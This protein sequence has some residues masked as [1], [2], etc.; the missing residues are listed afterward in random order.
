MTLFFKGL[1]GG[2]NMKKNMKNPNSN[3]AIIK[4][5]PTKKKLLYADAINKT[6]EIEG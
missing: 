1:K 5:A 4:K 6:V 2:L 3:K